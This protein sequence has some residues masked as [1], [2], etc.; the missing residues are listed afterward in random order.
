MLRITRK[1]LKYSDGIITRNLAG[2]S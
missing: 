2:S 1:I